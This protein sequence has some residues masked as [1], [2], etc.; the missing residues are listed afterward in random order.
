MTQNKTKPKRTV[1]FRERNHCQANGQESAVTVLYNW[2][3]KF[4]RREHDMEINNKVESKTRHI[5]S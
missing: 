5:K 2:S 1:N 4:N 3:E